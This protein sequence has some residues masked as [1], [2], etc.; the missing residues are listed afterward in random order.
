MTDTGQ[1]PGEGLPESA[2]MVEQSGVPAPGPF[3]FLDPSEHP[4]E[5]DDLL[6][7]PGAQGAWSEAQ[8]A[9]PGIAQQPPT[10]PQ[11]A[12]APVR[13]AGPQG[14]PQAAPQGG[15][16]GVP[17]QPGAVS[18]QFAQAQ[19]APAAFGQAAA[20]AVPVGQAAQLGA[21]GQAPAEQVPAGQAQADQAQVPMQAAQA[22]QAQPVAAPAPFAQEQAAHQPGPHETAGRDSGS[23]DLTGVPLPS[24]PAHTPASHHGTSRRPLHRGPAAPAVPDG[25]ARPVLSLADRGPAGSGP[26]AVPVRRPG[27]PT[28]GPEYLDVPRE[29]TGALPGPQLGEIPPQGAMPWGAEPQQAPVVP[30][31]NPQGTPAET[32]VPAATEVPGAPGD[33]AVPTTSPASMAPAAPGTPMALVVTD[34]SDGTDATSAPDIPDIPSATD[35]TDAPSASDATDA[36]DTSHV[37]DAATANVTDASSASAVTEASDGTDTALVAD[38]TPA[39]ENTPVADQP[40]AADAVP[41]PVEASGAAG[42]AVA[43][44]GAQETPSAHIVGPAQAEG[45]ETADLASDAP[46]APGPPDAAVPHA[47]GADAPAHSAVP[48]PA[49]ASGQDA[50]DAPGEATG[51]AAAVTDG[52]GGPV[53]DGVPDASEAVTVRVAPG[54]PVPHALPVVDDQGAP[55]PFADAQAPGASAAQPEAAAVTPQAPDAA[56]PWP[57]AGAQLPPAVPGQDA[58]VPPPLGQFVPVEGSVPTTP[59]L[60]PTPPRP[61]A[62][63]PEYFAPQRPDEAVAQE[64]PAVPAPDAAPRGAAPDAAASPAPVPAAQ[65]PDAEEAVPQEWPVPEA[66]APEAVPAT[67]AH[68]EPGEQPVPTVPAPRDGDRPTAAPAAT[69]APAPVAVADGQLPPAQVT[70][71]PDEPMHAPHPAEP[72]DPAA[73]ADGPPA[74]DLAAPTGPGE[75][76]GL[77]EHL[78]DAP[79][80]PEDLGT[81]L[82]QDASDLAEPLPA[83][84]AAPAEPVTPLDPPAPG[85]ADAEREAVLRVMRERRDIRNG[86]R[87]DPIPHEVLLRVLEAAHTAPSVGHSQPW[88][89][90][91]IRSAETRRTMHELA[92]RQ[93]EAYAKSLPKGRAKQFKELKIEAILDTPVNIVVTADPTRGGRHTLGRH[94]QPQMAPYSS[95]LAVENLWLAARAEGLGVGWVS[96]FDER[97]MVRTLGLPEHLE[98]VAYLC[99]GYVDEFP[100]EPELMQAGWSKRRPLSWV[101]HEETYGRRALPGEDPHDLLAETVG[102]IRPLDAKALGE[103]WERQK[104]M[105]KPAGALGMLE[106]ISAQLSGLSRMCPPPIPEPAAVAIFAGDHGVHAQGVTSWPQEVT[107]QMVAN[108]LGGGAVCNAFATQVGAEVCVIDVGVASELPATPGLLP[109]KIRPGTAD[110]TTGPALTRDEVKAAVEVGIETARD[111][112]AAGNKAL[113]TG[114]MGIANTTASAALISVYTDLDPLEVT[115]RGTGINDEMHARKV[116]VV[117]RALELHQPDPADPIGVLAA[118]GGLE[119]AAMVG[120]LLGGASLRTPVILDGVSAGAAALVARA[121][122]PEVL[123]ACIAGHR[124]A[125]PGHVAA[126]NKLGLRPLVDLDL[127]LGEGTGALLALP[128]VQSAARAMHEVATFDSAGVTEK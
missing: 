21:V 11:A 94:T 35:N 95:A 121:I 6:L 53:A 72:T 64:P 100:E 118:I 125:E 19:G 101:V 34:S 91:V 88:D 85:Y 51:A 43:P 107:G 10:G 83:D 15:A 58:Q 13:T 110:M 76:T 62:V 103:A 47:P 89:F 2:G 77:P 28:S 16:P 41:E 1:V 44:E 113:L 38:A 33:P 79:E 37:P 48:D 17:A 55:V 109:R 39:P 82:V 32:V 127:R 68:A 70:T 59:H 123:A 40:S 97:E 116:E 106:I 73:P 57:E 24:G 60:A 22:V 27:P 61:L 12:A 108:F 14:A 122:A 30:A 69:A 81:P 3:A 26:N 67:G 102:N 99:V 7:M 65:L 120:L 8:A 126:L 36:A 54:V 52:V 25:A 80:G 104:R 18:A 74:P 5:D 4:A 112:V 124:S 111:L 90:V 114:E 98:V 20:V 93:R 75:A 29:D 23:V 128:I 66:A 119:H 78:A 96:F 86:F 31:Q 71:D 87:G 46:D 84:S 117:R 92:Q 42:D 49:A 50:A 63:P 9:Q 115:G 45:A 56:Q 105:T